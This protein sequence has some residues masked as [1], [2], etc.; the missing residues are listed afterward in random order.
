[1][2][3]V[4]EFKFSS[5][6]KREVHHGHLFPLKFMFDFSKP[7]TTAINII[8]QSRLIIVLA[9]TIFFLLKT[10]IFNVFF[11]SKEHRF[12]EDARFKGKK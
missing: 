5:G 12:F 1:M 2:L 8:T 11:A 6:S 3:F 10:N 4:L 7:L 9:I